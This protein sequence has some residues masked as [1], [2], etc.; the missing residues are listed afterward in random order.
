MK[1]SVSFNITSKLFAGV[2]LC[3]VSA[4]AYSR[5]RNQALNKK[6]EAAALL[7]LEERWKTKLETNLKYAHEALRHT[8][9][10]L[11]YGAIN[12]QEDLRGVSD[13][14]ILRMDDMRNEAE[15]A[16]KQEFQ[17]HPNLDPILEV[18]SRIAKKHKIGNCAEQSS[19]A[20]LYLK[21]DKNLRK[22]ERLALIN[23]D[24]C[25]IVIGRDP[26]GDVRDPSTW[27][28]SAVVCDPWG[29]RYFPAEQLFDQLNKLSPRTIYDPNVH[30]I[31]WTLS[32]DTPPEVL[33]YQGLRFH[34]K[35]DKKQY[36][37]AILAN[38]L[39]DKTIFDQMLRSCLMEYIEKKSKPKVPPLLSEDD[40]KKVDEVYKKYLA[41]E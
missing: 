1:A 15:R 36:A 20:Y 9:E 29:K 34:H 28:K 3:T 8:N 17:L 7:Q 6:V 37:E 16:L 4:F 2:A 32:G 24:H 40:L 21:N 27:G 5:Y 39:D 30:S 11:P 26:L 41:F 31:G 12:Y 13:E 22:V 38:V 14:M 33:I 23:G 35:I 18:I 10:A 25:F 19:V